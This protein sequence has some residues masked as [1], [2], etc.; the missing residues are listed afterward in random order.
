MALVGEASLL[1]SNAALLANVLTESIVEHLHAG[2]GV[3]LEHFLE[4]IAVL[5]HKCNPRG[6]H[7]AD[8]LSVEVMSASPTPVDERSRVVESRLRPGAYKVKHVFDAKGTHP[9]DC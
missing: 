1:I 8:Q 5:H 9:G 3:D 4:V 6:R 7:G 2:I